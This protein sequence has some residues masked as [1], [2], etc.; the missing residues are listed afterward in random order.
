[1]SIPKYNE[2]MPNI[3]RYLAE[4]GEQQ[5]RSLEQPLASEFKLTEEQIS[6]EY[7]SLGWSSRGS[8]RCWG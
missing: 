3:L 2:I 8:E 4:H 7:E 6:Q 1:M 5:F